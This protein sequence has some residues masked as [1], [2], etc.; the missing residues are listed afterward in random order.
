MFSVLFLQEWHESSISNNMSGEAPAIILTSE[1]K[2][3]N[4]ISCLIN[5]VTVMFTECLIEGRVNDC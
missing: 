1:K 5:L 2:F 4:Y 3:N